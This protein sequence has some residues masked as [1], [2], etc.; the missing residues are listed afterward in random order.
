MHAWGHIDLLMSK[1][2]DLL[3]YN[4]DTSFVGGIHLEDGGLETITQ[5]L[6]CHAQNTGR[7]TGA[8]RSLYTK[9]NLSYNIHINRMKALKNTYGM[10]IYLRLG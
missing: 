4:F 6:P 2:L 8:W 7:F 3:S 9:F 5:H 1:A 10:C